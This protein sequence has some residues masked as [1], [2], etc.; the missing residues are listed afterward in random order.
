[1]NIL[2]TGGAG[3]IGSNLIK[4]LFTEMSDA[5]IV[6]IDNLNDYYDPSLKE[7]RLRE[8]AEAKPDTVHHLFV[9]GSIADRDLVNKLFDDYKFDIVVNLAAQAGV[10]YSIDNPD[11]Y[12]ESN[13]IGFYNILEACRHHP[14]KHL[15]YA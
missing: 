7:F 10:R 14:V 2:V 4:R 11:V 8:L 1:M 5:T 15:V 12:I 6:N 9:R 13:V 3:F